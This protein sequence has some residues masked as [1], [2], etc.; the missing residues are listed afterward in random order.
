M[1]TGWGDYTRS[2]FA[3]RGPPPPPPPP[4]P[5]ATRFARGGRGKEGRITLHILITGAAGM[6][7]R[8]LTARLLAD[9]ALHG[10]A[11]EKLTLHDV[12]RFPAETL[13]GKPAPSID[14]AT[15]DLAGPGE[16]AKLIAA[17]PDAIFHLAGVVSGEAELDFDKGYHVNLD[18]MRAVLDAIRT[19]GGGYHP[20]LVFSSS[21][22]VY[23][24]PFPP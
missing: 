15:G 21:I 10:R 8:K 2:E 11:I 24:A 23:G 18:G 14:I 13:G 4:P 3:A 22:A 5:P 12:V 7:G 17:R 19:A 6:I 9:G 1:R 20:K 16:A